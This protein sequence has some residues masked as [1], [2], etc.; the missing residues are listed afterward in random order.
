[1]LAELEWERAQMITI[2]VK[3]SENIQFVIPVCGKPWEGVSSILVTLT[4]RCG[5]HFERSNISLSGR[6]LDDVDLSP[7]RLD[8]DVRKNI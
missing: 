6:N 4:S 8:F 5:S 3:R 2:L 7:N 1:M